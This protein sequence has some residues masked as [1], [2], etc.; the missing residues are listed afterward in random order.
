M[1]DT[2]NENGF[3]F[4]YKILKKK[5]KKNRIMRNINTSTDFLNDLVNLTYL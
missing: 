5:K 3:L 2:D 4:L 1:M